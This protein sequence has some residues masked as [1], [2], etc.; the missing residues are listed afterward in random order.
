MKLSDFNYELPK[1]FIAQE[2]V[3]P[4]DSSKLMVV[5]RKNKTIQHKV[6]SD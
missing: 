3:T 1:E 5:D 2:P 6:F 4:R